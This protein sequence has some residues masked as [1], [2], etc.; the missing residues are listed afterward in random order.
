V[1]QDADV[2]ER[3]FAVVRAVAEPL[4]DEGVA[5]LDWLEPARG[6]G[7]AVKLWPVHADALAVEVYPDSVSIVLQLG[8]ISDE[9]H[10]DP[11]GTDPDWEDQLRRMLQAVVGGGFSELIEPERHGYC[12]TLRFRQGDGEDLVRRCEYSGSVE[13]RETRFPG[14]R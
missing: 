6:F 10:P 12:R 7:P 2:R 8:D 14:F 13:R 3:A 5:R 1:A 9:L 4:V 11:G